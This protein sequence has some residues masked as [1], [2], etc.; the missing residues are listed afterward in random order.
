MPPI[1]RNS[2]E[3]ESRGV[4]YFSSSRSPMAEGSHA[5][6][7]NSVNVPD[8]IHPVSH[9]SWQPSS[10]RSVSP[11]QTTKKARRGSTRDESKGTMEADSLEAEGMR[12]QQGQEPRR[13]SGGIEPAISV[14]QPPKRGRGRPPKQKVKDE[15]GVGTA[16]ALKDRRASAAETTERDGAH[17]NRADEISSVVKPSTQV[18]S[19]E[20]KEIKS[21]FDEEEGKGDE[22]TAMRDVE[23][24]DKQEERPS[25]PILSDVPYA[26]RKRVSV[27]TVTRMPLTRAEV[28]Q[29]RGS[30]QNPLRLKWQ[31]E[32]PG[33]SDG[34]ETVVTRF[35]AEVAIQPA[36]ASSKRK[37]DST[38]VN[39]EEDAASLVAAHYNSRTDVGLSARRES[40]ILPLRQFNN[41]VKS[42]LIGQFTQ[43]GAR[44]L[45]LGG[46]K[47]GDLQKWEKAR[48]SEY[49]LADIADVSVKQAEQRYMERRMRFQAQFYAFDCFSQPLADH[50]DAELLRRKFTNVSLQFCMHY[51]WESVSKANLMLENIARYLEPGGFFVGTIPN[52]DEL[53][54]RL[55]A[56][57]DPS[58]PEDEEANPTK[59]LKFGNDFYHVTF[60]PAQRD[61]KPKKQLFGH[62]YRFHLIDAVEGV[63]EYVVDWDEFVS[64][65]DQNG[66]SC[67]YK[68][69][70]GEVWNQEGR[71]RDYSELARRMKVDVPFNEQQTFPP[72]MPPDL[73][74]ACGAHSPLQRDYSSANC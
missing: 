6:L 2:A 41:W 28:D 43:P 51:G 4:S 44:V 10:Q 50:I 26:P 42:V 40:P 1:R 53:R 17:D 57:P 47:G 18:V 21:R 69:R 61:K 39:G 62:R 58:S 23:D 63:D 12:Q 37:R 49:I 9:R 73:W 27:P 64:L 34:W 70:F 68:K 33:L 11:P 38:R 52:C 35:G 24:E 71:T 31:D 60:D 25:H 8:A 65:A 56:L 14:D 19:S 66:L 59:G 55:R 7:S 32:N 54:T 20:A 46:G 16:A 48:I 45:D 5:S 3:G 30:S 74:E 15:T 29:L 67:V 13:L 22:D 36:T 72:S